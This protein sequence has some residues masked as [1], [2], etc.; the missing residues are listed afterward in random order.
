MGLRRGFKSEANWYAR[1]FRE[2]IGLEPFEPLCPWQLADHLGLPVVSLE[3]FA[4]KHPAEVA[5]LRSSRGQK[6]FS[7]VTVCSN[8]HRLVV[9]NDGHSPKR[10]RA[11][12]AHE[13]SHGIL[14][15]PPSPPFGCDGT[16][17]YDV[18]QEEE[19]SWLGP[20]LLISE[21]AALWIARNDYSVPAAS[22]LF[23]VSEA[24]VRM[25]LNVT[26]ARRRLA[27][28]YA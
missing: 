26:G 18:T 17:G 8:R 21:E 7:A 1:I 14:M 25:R 28:S 10:Q 4:I 19:A 9:F 20:A 5:Y 22:E 15:H 16:R 13:L 12:I 11:D 6:D 23:G 2:E 24:L 3:E 27:R